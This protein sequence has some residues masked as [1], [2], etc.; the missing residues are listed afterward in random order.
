MKKTAKGIVDLVLKTINDKESKTITEIA[1]EINSNQTTVKEYIEL[2]IKIQQS[3][4]IIIEKIKK[5]TL[6]KLEKRA[7][8]K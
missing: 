6:I 7:D 3:P 8:E 4:K 2:M 5:L 1:R